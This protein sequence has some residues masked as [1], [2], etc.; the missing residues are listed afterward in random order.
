MRRAAPTR[1]ADASKRP[2]PAQRPA[3]TAAASR[4]RRPARSVAGLGS[5]ISAL[6][7]RR[8]LT[9][10]QHEAAKKKAAQGAHPSGDQGAKRVG[11]RF[12]L[13]AIA[14]PGRIV[15]AVV[16][17]LLVLVIGG[18]VVSNSPVFAV[19]D[20]VVKGSEHI[21]QETVERLVSVPEGSTMFNIDASA[22]EASLKQNPW[23]EG[24][25]I[26]RSFPHTVTITPVEYRV[27][28]IAYITSTDVAW[29]IDVNGTWIAP[30][31]L[32]VTVDADGNVVSTASD[33]RQV[34]SSGEGDGA[35]A[36]GD[37]AAT[38]A[39][40]ADD[41]S[42]SSDDSTGASSDGAD[43]GSA[44]DAAAT[45]ESDGADDSTAVDGADAAGDDAAG[46]QADAASADG[47]QVLTGI[48]AARA[49]ARRDGAVLFT[50]IMADVEPSE[51]TQVSSEVISAG[52]AYVNGF[53][54]DFIAQI[55]DLS[56]ESVDAISLD[57]TNGVEVALGEPTD[58]SLK[59][60]VITGLLDQVEGIT[61]I[62]ARTPES[63]TYRSAPAS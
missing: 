22:I 53:S 55:E 36:A 63:P 49:L 45:D 5:A 12:K 20:V 39:D 27:A 62:D 40:G 58:I 23:V 43:A 41:A 57:L 44:D 30:L 60:R 61:Y 21:P 3:P 47:S 1:R 29:A 6:K 37:D 8:S 59:E 25:K 17:L 15:A 50:D 52:L 10:I 34:A 9:S 38:G 33:S 51:G 24:V 19:T 54:D 18:I 7:P 4:S 31:S 28:A 35:A 16:A 46:D 2:A 56:L 32:S 11:A 13:P 14:I 48:D 26:D 42:G